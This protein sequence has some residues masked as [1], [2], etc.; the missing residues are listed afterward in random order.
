M[1]RASELSGQTDTGKNNGTTIEIPLA[2]M[3]DSG[4][5]KY[6]ILINLHQSRESKEPI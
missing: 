2:K 1:D 6:K 3:L 5:I 4:S